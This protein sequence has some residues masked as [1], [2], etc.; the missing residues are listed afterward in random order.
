M[1][2]RTFAGPEKHPDEMPDAVL[3]SLGFKRERSPHGPGE[4]WTHPRNPG[5]FFYHII[6][7]AM[8]TEA[9][10]ETGHAEFRARAAKYIAGVEMSEKEEE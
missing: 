1:S 3:S 7:P 9:L 5:V 2:A 6:T 4:Y 8:V 10:I